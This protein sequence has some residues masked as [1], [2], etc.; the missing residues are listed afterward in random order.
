MSMKRLT[1]AVGRVGPMSQFATIEHRNAAIAKV[2]LNEL[3]AITQEQAKSGSIH[4]QQVHRYTTQA[5]CNIVL[6]VD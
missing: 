4:D 3:V 1:D 6:G 5:V 2:M